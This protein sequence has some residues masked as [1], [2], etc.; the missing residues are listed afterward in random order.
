MG[1]INIGIPSGKVRKYSWYCL[2]YKLFANFY[3]KKNCVQNK[4]M[5]MEHTFKVHIE[6][7]MRQIWS[8]KTDIIDETIPFLSL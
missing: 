8:F 2:S 4:E 5:A 1:K 7:S 6:Y 3:F